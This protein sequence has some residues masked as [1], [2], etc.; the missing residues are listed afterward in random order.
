[1]LLLVAAPC[2]AQPA[3][4]VAVLCAEVAQLRVEVDRLKLE[5]GQLRRLLA[6]APE[7][8]ADTL[9]PVEETVGPAQAPAAAEKPTGFWLSTGG[10][11][12]NAKCRY[13][14]QSAGRPCGPKE[15]T[16][17]KKCGG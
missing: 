4:S 6:G 13:Y 14:R 7:A 9:V 1:M 11:R 3:D 5:I 17:C 2:V 15:G 12:H 8:A 16:A 10:T